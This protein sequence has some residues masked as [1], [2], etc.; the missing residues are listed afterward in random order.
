MCEQLTPC[1]LPSHNMN[2]VEMLQVLLLYKNEHL[3]MI[4]LNMPWKWS[5]DRKKRTRCAFSL[6][7]SAFSPGSRQSCESNRSPVTIE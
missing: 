2:T 1:L 4:L 3:R 5:P 7:Q 6:M